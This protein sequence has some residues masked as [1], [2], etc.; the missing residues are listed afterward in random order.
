[1]RG[2]NQVNVYLTSNEHAAFRDY[3]SKFSL[4][5]AALLALL[6][7]RELRVARLSTL[8]LKDAPP[9]AA[10]N[11]KVTTRL[12]PSNRA[13]LVSLAQRQGMKLS[14]LG[15]LLVCAELDETWL[16]QACLT[17]FES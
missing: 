6:F 13:K 4:D 8:M 5:A 7:A 17:R 12:D 14:Q 2:E 11:A 9:D 10:K 3:A 1:M 15:R 16:E